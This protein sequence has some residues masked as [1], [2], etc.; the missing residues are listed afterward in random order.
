MKYRTNKKTGDRI[1]VIGLGTSYIAEISEKEAVGL[2]CLLMK[3]VSTMR[4]W[5]PP[6]RK[7]LHTT[8]RLSPS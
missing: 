5:Q 3:M 4:I 8:E 6:E 7:L 2:C 1:S